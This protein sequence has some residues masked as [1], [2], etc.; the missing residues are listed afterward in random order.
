MQ[1]DLSAE[2]EERPEAAEQTIN[3]EEE[4][5][6]D[7]SGDEGDESEGKGASDVEEDWGL[8]D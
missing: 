4:S 8:W 5:D 6:I 3:D 7:I 2:A 1:E